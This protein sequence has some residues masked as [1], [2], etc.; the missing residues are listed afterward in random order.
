MNTKTRTLLAFLATSAF[1]LQS[2]AASVLPF[3]SV[4][5]PLADQRYRFIDR[6]AADEQNQVSRQ[7]F[8]SAWQ[9]RFDAL[10]SFA[11]GK[12][13]EEVF[14][15]FE[16]TELEQQ[17]LNARE[18][19]IRQTLNRFNALDRDKDGTISWEEYQASGQR[20]FNRFDTMEAGVVSVG[21]PEPAP[22]QRAS[23]NNQTD[24]ERRRVRSLLAM[25]TTHNNQGFL[26]MF[27]GN[28]QQQVTLA[29]FEQQRRSIFDRTDVN[30][31]GLVS[32]GEYLDEFMARVGQREQDVRQAHR[33][34]AQQ[35]FRQMDKEQRGWLSKKDFVAYGLAVFQLWDTTNEQQ[36]S[37]AQ[38][39]PEQEPQLQL[40]AHQR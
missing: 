6:F 34:L 20:I 25:P 29:Q 9:Q 26:T 3:S 32:R 21:D 35:V 17:L 36:I 1:Y 24:T 7:D 40:V 38:P 16:M 18:A 39:L 27:A 15:A 12:I 11:D 19:H 5:E 4:E 31:D 28:E 22:R 14:V 2:A 10:A 23:N 33:Q 37:E 13:S 8:L 30:G